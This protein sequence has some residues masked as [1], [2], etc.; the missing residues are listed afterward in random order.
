MWMQWTA[1]SETALLS[2]KPVC[3]NVEGGAAHRG[4]TRVAAADA[5]P[6]SIRRRC[7]PPLTFVFAF[8]FAGVCAGPG[9]DLLSPWPCRLLPSRLFPDLSLPDL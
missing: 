6:C 2:A 1:L 5:I 8:A 7:G 3:S 9:P 4:R